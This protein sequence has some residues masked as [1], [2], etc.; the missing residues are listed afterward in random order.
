[1]LESSVELM[2][3]VS[4][5]VLPVLLAF[6]IVGSIVAALAALSGERTTVNKRS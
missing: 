1:M 4:L 3:I 5:I 6:C 2:E